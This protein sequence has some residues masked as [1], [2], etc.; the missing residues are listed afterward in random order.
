MKNNS[1]GVVRV[2]YT[3]KRFCSSENINFTAVCERGGEESWIGGSFHWRP[4]VV[5][6]V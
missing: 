5:Y 2:N 6:T 1:Y 3:Q 4:A